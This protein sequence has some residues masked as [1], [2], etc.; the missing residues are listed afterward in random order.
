M[1]KTSSD[2]G[3]D[4]RAPI[5]GGMKFPTNDSK[6]FA[7]KQLDMS[8][9]EVGAVQPSTKGAKIQDIVPK[10]PATTKISAA[11]TVANYQQTRK[12]RR[13]IRVHNLVKKAGDPMDPI[14]TDPLV[15]YLRK[16]A[17]ENRVETNL[18]NM[19]TGP[20]EKEL[21]TKCPCPTSELTGEAQSGKSHVNGLFQEGNVK[22]KYT[23]KDHEKGL[24]TVNEVKPNLESSYAEGV[25]DRVLGLR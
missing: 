11:K 2:A 13:P 8:S 19:P 22:P 14:T 7:K 9:A 24:N 18:S 10:M 23:E 20:E 16:Q 6:Q 21:S 25:V 1:K 5:V 15:R 3:Q 17:Q 4:L 12:G